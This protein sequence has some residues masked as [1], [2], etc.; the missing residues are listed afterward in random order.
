MAGD[1]CYGERRRRWGSAVRE[2]EGE[3]EKHGRE[4]GIRPGERGGTE[5][6]RRG[7]A[8]AGGGG[9]QTGWW[10]G[11]PA[12]RARRPHAWPT[13]ARRTTAVVG[14]AGL[15]GRPAG[16]AAQGGAQVSSSCYLFFCF[17]I[18]DICF[19]LN[20]ILNHLFNLCQFLQELDILFQSSFI[21]GIIFGHILIYI[22]NIFPMQI[23]M[24]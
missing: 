19:D 20:N 17:L 2:R 1:G 16:W 9:R 5:K 4:R 11:A 6:K 15:L 10:R 18:S 21:I 22:T 8:L 3:G 24:H 14:W 7:V 13:G 12:V 23:F